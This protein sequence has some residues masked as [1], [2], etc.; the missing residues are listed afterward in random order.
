MLSKHFGNTHCFLTVRQISHSSP[1]Q[2]TAKIKF[3]IVTHLRC[4]LAP[5]TSRLHFILDGKHNELF[6]ACSQ[7]S[8]LICSF[9]LNT[10]SG[11]ILTF[12]CDENRYF[13]KNPSQN[14]AILYDKSWCRSISNVLARFFKQLYSCECFYIHN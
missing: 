1:L 8:R 4:L 12:Y 2:H 5:Y 6:I 10:C 11:Y 7:G 14:F 13:L 3:N 9:N